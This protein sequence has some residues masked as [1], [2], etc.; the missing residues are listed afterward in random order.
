LTKAGAGTDACVVKR[1]VDGLGVVGAFHS[2]GKG[3]YLGFVGYIADVGGYNYL[4]IV[5]STLASSL[6]QLGL[7]DITQSELTAFGP[8]LLPNKP[9]SIE[10]LV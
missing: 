7:G 2:V 3:Q 5:G 8:S 9:E 4:W 10:A 1:Q 6:I